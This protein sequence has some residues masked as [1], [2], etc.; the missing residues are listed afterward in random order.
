ML[1]DPWELGDTGLSDFSVPSIYV[2]TQLPILSK[3]EKE[4]SRRNMLTEQPNFAGKFLGK[5]VSEMKP[6]GLVLSPSTTQFSFLS[7][8]GEN[9]EPKWIAFPKSMFFFKNNGEDGFEFET[10]T[11]IVIEKNYLFTW[12]NANRRKR[13]IFL[14]KF[15]LWKEKFEL[16]TEHVM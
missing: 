6:F 12:W 15:M 9:V 10:F 7:L 4:M 2:Q 5:V 1:L 3:E 13:Y 14:S 8:I 11:Y 16:K